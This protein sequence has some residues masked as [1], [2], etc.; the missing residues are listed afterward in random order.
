MKIA[1]RRSFLKKSGASALGLF[2]GN[3]FISCTKQ[4]KQQISQNQRENMPEAA[5]IAIQLWTVRELI[6]KDAKGT[7]MKLADIGYQAVETA[8]FPKHISISKGAELIEE[9]GLKVCSVHIELPKGDEQ[10]RILEMSE[11][12]D[13]KD[14][15]WH[16][17][18]EEKRY[19]NLG[20]IED[21]A[22]EFNEAH[23]FCAS[24]NLKFG[25]HNHWWEFETMI[26][27]SLPF[28][29]LRDMLHRDIFLEIDT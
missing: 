11:A 10:K 19:K 6:E 8:F 14:M 25:L 26:D 12:Y 13:C 7:L 15:I 28:L 20:G 5:P 1:N 4:E 22:E 27:G 21:L 2:L 24:H 9:A 3:S 18:P 23:A 17:W 29:R 16:G